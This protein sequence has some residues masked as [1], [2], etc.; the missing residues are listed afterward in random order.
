MPNTSHDR[1]YLSSATH[2]AS[3]DDRTAFDCLVEF[4]A[5]L[6]FHLG[7]STPEGFDGWMYRYEPLIL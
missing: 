5:Q 1:C 3:G 7:W 4:N 6:G 2:V